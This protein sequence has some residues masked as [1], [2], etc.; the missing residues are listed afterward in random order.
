MFMKPQTIHAMMKQSFKARGLYVA[1]IH[2]NLALAGTGWAVFIIKKF[3]PNEIKAET[4]KLTG[5][6]PLDGMCYTASEDGN[7]QAF[8][9]AM[10]M[11]LFKEVEKHTTRELE[12]TLIT[13]RGI[14]GTYRIYDGHPDRPIVVNEDMCQKIS[15][16][17]CD[18]EEEIFGPCMDDNGRIY[19]QS[20]RMAFAYMETDLE[21][22]G[23]KDKDA[24][25]TIWK[26]WRT[27]TACG[28]GDG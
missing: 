4:V 8:P 6:L 11:N 3:C 10:Q 23:E 7:Q 18:E 14:F 19:W 5:E 12:D 13:V 27:L 28:T 25:D 17:L 1:S 24:A 20:S 21:I 2:G 22:V 9:E 16:R 26:A 15:N